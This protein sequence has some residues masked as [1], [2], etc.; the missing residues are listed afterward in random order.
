SAGTTRQ[1]SIAVIAE[2]RNSLNGIAAYMLCS[3]ETEFASPEQAL[4][5]R[6]IAHTTRF[7][8]VGSPFRVHVHP[9]LSCRCG[10]SDDPRDTPSRQ[11]SCVASAPATLSQPAAF[12]E[13]R[14]CSAATKRS[15]F[16]FL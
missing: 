14:F 8:R 1:K 4:C 6:S 11:L 3:V 5:N 7:Q 10:A 12:R 15:R 16:D 9:Q 13:D 2:I